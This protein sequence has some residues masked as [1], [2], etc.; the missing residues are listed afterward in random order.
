MKL[1]ITS[2]GKTLDSKIEP[3]FGRSPYFIIY[4]T[5]TDDFEVIENQNVAASSGVGI[6]SGQLVSDKKIHVVL[7]GQVGPKALDALQAANIDIVT[8]VVSGTG[9]VKEVIDKY[10]FSCVETTEKFTKKQES[11][12]S[13]EKENIK[14]PLEKEGWFG[15]CVRRWFRGSKKERG[16]FSQDRGMRRGQEGSGRKGFAGPDD[17]CLCPACGEKATHQRGVTCRSMRCPKCNTNMIR[18]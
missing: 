18:K 12:E 17:Y 4:D 8:D 5:D 3:R 11:K 14:P 6:K 10:Q 13:E 9:T 7:T 1:C 16:R 2:Q 15:R